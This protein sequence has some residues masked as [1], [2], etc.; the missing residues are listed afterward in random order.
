MYRASNDYILRIPS[1]YLRYLANRSDT[2]QKRTEPAAEHSHDGALLHHPQ[3]RQQSQLQASGHGETADCCYQRLG[4]LQT[5][6]SLRETT[7]SEPIL[8]VYSLHTTNRIN[9]EDVLT[10]QQALL[11]LFFIISYELTF[12]HFQLLATLAFNYHFATFSKTF[13]HLCSHQTICCF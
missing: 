9:K 5:G 6:R 2:Q 3:I 12:C 1:T 13:C 8:N 4:Q 11:W 7:G 10:I